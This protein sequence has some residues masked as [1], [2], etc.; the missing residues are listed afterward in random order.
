MKGDTTNVTVYTDELVDS[1]SMR[2]SDREDND[3]I[4][5]NKKRV[6]KNSSS[7]NSNSIYDMIYNLTRFICNCNY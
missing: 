5:M 7:V 1:V 6:P 2:L 4:V 3:K